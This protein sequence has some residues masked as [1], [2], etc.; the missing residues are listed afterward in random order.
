MASLNDIFHPP[1]LITLGIVILLIAAC[2]AYFESKLRDQNH[3]IASMLS[4]VSSLA[5]EINFAKH[6]L[7]NI[8]MIVGG[9][10]NTHS[11]NLISGLEANSL[12]QV[13]DG[14]DTDDDDTDDDDT[15]DDDDA[16]TDDGNTDEDNDTD[17]DNDVDTVDVELNSDKPNTESIKLFK[18]TINN[19]ELIDN[20]AELDILDDLEELDDDI[21]DGLDE[22]VDELSDIEP[23]S[24]TIKIVVDDSKNE[25]IDYKKL[26][27]TQLRLIASG[28]KIT[29]DVSKMKKP[30]LLK[31]LQ[32]FI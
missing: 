5:E 15:D 7:N 26:S 10:K 8:T 24:K 9:G 3:K 12:I 20:I 6:S 13:S 21:E 28:K 1:F 19:D 25:P 32:T 22:G 29:A 16:D 23:N 27:V 18:M 31:L 2:V 4:L 11:N 17:Q 14:D 30:E